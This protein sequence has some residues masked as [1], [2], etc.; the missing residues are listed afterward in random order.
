MIPATMMTTIVMNP[1]I[2]SWNSRK[3]RISHKTK[4]SKI[5]QGVAGATITA[6]KRQIMSIKE[7]E[8]I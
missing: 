2:E 1:T 7:V 5:C 3:D 6:S 4:T 8:Y